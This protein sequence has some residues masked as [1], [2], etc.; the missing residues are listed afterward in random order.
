M[1]HG[2]KLY[3]TLLG[4]MEGTAAA[5]GDRFHSQEMEKTRKTRRL[6]NASGGEIHTLILEEEQQKILGAIRF[7]R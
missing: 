4:E 3:D 1:K 7:K 2:I 6:G 5:A